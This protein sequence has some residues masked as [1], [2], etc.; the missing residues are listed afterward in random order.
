MTNPDI[1]P[2]HVEHV[3]NMLQR[4]FRNLKRVV[5]ESDPEPATKSLLIRFGHTVDDASK[6][7]TE[8]SKQQTEKK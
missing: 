3:C 8:L 7:L 2:T 1:T 4:D 5:N 6:M